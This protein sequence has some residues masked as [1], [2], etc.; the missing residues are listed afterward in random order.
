MTSTAILIPARL[1]SKRYP[2]KMLVSLDGTPLIKR[3]FDICNPTDSNTYVVTD[4]EEIA[5]WF[6]NYILTDEAP[7]VQKDVLSLARDPHYDYYINVQGDMSDI[8]VP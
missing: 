3:V 5:S 2:N 7:M 8:T 4:S 1:E 6:P